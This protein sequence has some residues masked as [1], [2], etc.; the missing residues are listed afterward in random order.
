MTARKKKMGMVI[1]ANPD[2]YPPVINAIRLLAQEFNLVVISRNQNMP[3]GVGYPKN[4]RIYR[5][6]SLKI[7]RVKKTQSLAMKLFEYIS[8]TISAIFYIRS[9][10]CQLIY[11]YDMH[12]FLA[13]FV[14]SRLGKKIPLVYHNLDLCALE[15]L[16]DTSYGIKYLEL[17]LARYADK[18]IF[19]DINR[20]R[21][22]QEKAK[23]IEPPDIVMNAPLCINPM[24]DDRLKEILKSKRFSADTKA[25]LYQGAVN[26]EH[27]LLEVIQSI[28]YWPENTILVL[29]GTI[30]DDFLQEIYREAEKLNFKQRIINFS[31]MPYSELSSYTVGAHLG[32]ALYNAK[33][34]NQI[35]VAGASNKI[36]EYIS[37]GIPVI[38]ND[39]PHFH[40]VLDASIAYFARPDSAQDIAQAVNSACRESKVYQKKSEACRLAHLSKFNYE[41]QFNPVLEY[42]KKVTKGK[43]R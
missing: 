6:G 42:V 39:L 22:F 10:N 26:K 30:Y 11:S 41:V 1:Y 34:I 29:I 27:A 28:V 38:T 13:G 15:D 35:F 14:A 2:Y 43:I 20:A 32:L 40:E 9:Y 23:L 5:L 21:L 4:V 24:P 31:F 16:K 37:L 8:F 7:D 36:F 18:I 12:G 3:Q 19:P 25:I 17:R 33:D